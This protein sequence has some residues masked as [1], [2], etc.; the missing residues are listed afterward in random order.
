MIIIC[1][2]AGYSPCSFAV[3]LSDGCFDLWAVSF[4]DK[5]GV[6]GSSLFLYFLDVKWSLAVLVEL[7]LAAY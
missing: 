3:W 5:P 6:K 4:L 7:D 1:H 2:S